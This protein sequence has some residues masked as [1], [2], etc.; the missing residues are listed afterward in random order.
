MNKLYVLINY[1]K[2]WGRGWGRFILRSQR[3]QG[4]PNQ[5]GNFRDDRNKRYLLMTLTAYSIQ[6]T[7]SALC[8][9]SQ[10]VT[11]NL[12]DQYYYCD[13]MA[14]EKQRPREV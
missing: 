1:M 4:K 7:L 5:K 9:L 6:P 2:P 3:S 13:F 10:S 12:Y 14:K 11:I 8:V